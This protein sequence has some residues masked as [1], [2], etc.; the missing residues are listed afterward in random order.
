[1]RSE[2][3]KNYK[4]EQSLLQEIIINCDKNNKATLSAD[5]MYSLI[6]LKDKLIHRSTEWDKNHPMYNLDTNKSLT[7]SGTFEYL[8]FDLISI[9]K[10]FDFENSDLVAFCS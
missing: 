9:Y 2:I 4:K 5:Q 1:M 10:H 8:I 6:K 7:D 3:E